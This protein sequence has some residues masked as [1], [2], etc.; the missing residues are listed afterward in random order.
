[1]FS[2]ESKYDGK[3]ALTEYFRSFMYFNFNRVKISVGFVIWRQNYS[4]LQSLVACMLKDENGKIY[5][6]FDYIKY[7]SLNLISLKTFKKLWLRLNDDH[8]EFVE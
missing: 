6:C 8:G 1:M 2:R 7:V 3:A 5:Y 4:F